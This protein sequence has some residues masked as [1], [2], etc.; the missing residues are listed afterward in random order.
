MRTT[1]SRSKLSIDK[2]AHKFESCY[3]NKENF[4]GEKQEE[5]GWKNNLLTIAIL[6]TDD[7]LAGICSYG[8]TS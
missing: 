2:M 4:N 3:E 6:R 5:E 1:I 8:E 7:L